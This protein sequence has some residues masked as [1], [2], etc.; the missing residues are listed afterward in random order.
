MSILQVYQ[1]DTIHVMDGGM[2]F[3][4]DRDCVL[5]E[6]SSFFCKGYMYRVVMISKAD[7]KVFVKS[8]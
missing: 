6:N 2:D 3:Q 8:K 1:G 5:R 7:R 4:I